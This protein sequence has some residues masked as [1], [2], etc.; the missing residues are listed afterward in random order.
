L[1]LVLP[2]QMMIDLLFSL[3]EERNVS[4]GEPLNHL[5]QYLI[6]NVEQ[7]PF[8]ADGE[9]IKHDHL[10]VGAKDHCQAVRWPASPKR[11]YQHP[12]SMVRRTSRIFLLQPLQRCAALCS[13]F[14]SLN[15]SSHF[16][17]QVLSGLSY[18]QNVSSIYSPLMINLSNHSICLGHCTACSS[19]ECYPKSFVR[20][21]GCV[22]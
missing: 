12:L 5:Y 3:E 15:I 10:V 13:F 7:L 21:D 2:I 16:H 20:V 14:A 4:V 6:L 18:L 22:Q 17:A 11:N 19:C 9:E 1:I 8:S